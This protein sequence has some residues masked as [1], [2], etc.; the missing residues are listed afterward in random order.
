[1][2]DYK[3]HFRTNEILRDPITGAHVPETEHNPPL[4]F[5]LKKDRIEK[6]NIAKDEP[7]VLKRM[8]EEYQAMV[9]EITSPVMQG[10][11]PVSAR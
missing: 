7:E 9:E 6:I 11:V 10:Q 4:L 3:I 1:L 5:N 8:I 2:G